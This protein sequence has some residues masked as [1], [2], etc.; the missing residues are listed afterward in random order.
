MITLDDFP[1]LIDNRKPDINKITKWFRK[2]IKQN[3]KGLIEG[4]YKR[5]LMGLLVSVSQSMSTAKSTIESRGMLMSRMMDWKSIVNSFP[6]VETDGDETIKMNFDETMFGSALI[7]F[8][9]RDIKA[10]QQNPHLYQYFAP[11]EPVGTDEE[12]EAKRQAD[13]VEVTKKYGTHLFEWGIPWDAEIIE[14]VRLW[15]N[16][17]ESYFGDQGNQDRVDDFVARLE[18]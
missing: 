10:E 3:D 6:I 1:A 2:A 7:N 12:I 5:H 8:M 9:V 14:E 4:G 17:G 15:L 11:T 18:D 16:F 13:L